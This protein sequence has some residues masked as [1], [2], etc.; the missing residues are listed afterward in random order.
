[1]RAGN[2]T[3]A[4]GDHWGIHRNWEESIGTGNFE[5]GQPHLGTGGSLGDHGGDHWGRLVPSLGLWTNYKK[6]LV[7]KMVGFFVSLAL[8]VS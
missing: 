3:W 7:L 6:Q 1:M 5:G 4:L 2:P 8:G